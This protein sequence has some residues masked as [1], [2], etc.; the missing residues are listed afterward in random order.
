[1]TYPNQYGQQYPGAQAAPQAP[2]RT[3][4]SAQPGSANPSPKPRHLKDHTVIIDRIRI[5]E[6]AKA[7]GSNDIRPRALFK[8]I[9]VDGPEIFYGEDGRN[10]N[11]RPTHRVMPPCFFEEADASNNWV[12]DPIRRSSSGVVMGAIEEGTQGQNGNQPF[13]LTLPDQ[14][15]SGQPRPDGAQRIAAAQA[16]FERYEAGDMTWAN[17]PVEINPQPQGSAPA[18]QGYGQQPP[19]GPQQ[20]WGQP[21]YGQQA[22]PAMTAPAIDLSTP[23]SPEWAQHWATMP[24]AMKMQ[25]LATSQGAQ[26]QAASFPA[27]VPPAPQAQNG[28][29]PQGWGQPNI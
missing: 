22:P 4:E 14:F 25:V 13:F 27:S 8:L 16:L 5:D 24:D 3:L 1:M 19:Q 15:V 18:Q 11:A 9:V 10:R 7:M 29:Q 26:P 28:G 2:R 20:G 12:V 6:N 17:Q 23:P 21:G